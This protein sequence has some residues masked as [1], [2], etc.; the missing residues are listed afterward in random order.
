MAFPDLDSTP[1]RTLL[2]GGSGAAKA[3]KLEKLYTEG[4][5]HGSP[6]P[7]Q[8]P[9]KRRKSAGSRFQGLR[10]LPSASPG[11]SARDAAPPY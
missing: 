8:A 1:S 7:R 4:V 5:S 6:G 2:A 9:M 10:R 11:F 3:K